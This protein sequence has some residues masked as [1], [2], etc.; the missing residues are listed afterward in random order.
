MADDDIAKAL[1]LFELQPPLTQDA[2][3]HKRQQLRHIWNPHRY[4]H[5]SNNPRKYMQMVRKAEAM[6]KDIDAAYE[7]LARWLAEHRS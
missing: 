2:L 1:A 6:S 7:T 3:N 4:A 5:L